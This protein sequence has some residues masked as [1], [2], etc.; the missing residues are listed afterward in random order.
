[1]PEIAI[2][3]DPD[4]LTNPDLDLRYVLPSR[5]EALTGGRLR[6][7][8]Y[9]YDAADRML[10]FLVTDDLAAGLPEVLQ[11]LA[12]LEVLGNRFHD[13]VVAVADEDHCADLSQYRIVHPPGVEGTLAST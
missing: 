10:V 3:L 8:A 2:R 9:D 4:R 11:T 1:M 7:D 6:D 5:L 13:A 12:S